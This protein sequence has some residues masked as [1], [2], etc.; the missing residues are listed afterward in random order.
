MVLQR[1]RFVMWMDTSTRFR[2]SYLDDLFRQAKQEGAMASLDKHS[3]ASHTHQDTFRFLQ[4]TPCLFKDLGEFQGGL[5]LLHTSHVT[6]YEYLL[7]PWVSCALIEDCMKTRKYTWWII[8]CMQHKH[9]HECHRS[10]MSVL[11]ILMYRLFHYSYRDHA[12]SKRYFRF[13]KLAYN[14]SWHCL[15]RGY[16]SCNGTLLPI[17]VFADQWNFA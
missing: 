5:V 17:H 8:D 9:Y 13:M 14:F 3:V 10:D 12:I 7:Q 1:H 6:V 11:S 16:Y 2:T 15:A 4:E